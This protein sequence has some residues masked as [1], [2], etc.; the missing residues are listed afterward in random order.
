MVGACVG[1]T[2]A[3]L[4]LAFALVVVVGLFVVLAIVVYQ[5]LHIVQATC[6]PAL[7]IK[8]KCYKVRHKLL[9]NYVSLLPL[10]TPILLHT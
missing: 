6:L 3:G 5:P 7:I 9:Q 8:V 4:A 2:V 10:F 1:C